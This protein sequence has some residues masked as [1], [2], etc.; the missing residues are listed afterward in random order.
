MTSQMRKWRTDQGMK[1]EGSG[2]EDDSDWEEEEDDD[3]DSDRDDT[4]VQ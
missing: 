4:I 3:D 1:E 2:D